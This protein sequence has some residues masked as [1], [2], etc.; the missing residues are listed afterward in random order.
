MKQRVF[1][2][3]DLQRMR[4]LLIEL[5]SAS[6]DFQVVGTACTEAEADQWLGA[7]G[8]AW[9]LAIIDMVLDE[10]S[11]SNVIRRAREQNYG[12]LIAVLSSCVT[13]NL[14]EHCYVLGA[15]KVFDEAQMTRFLLWLARVGADDA[16]HLQAA[17][18]E[19]TGVSVR[20]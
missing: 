8:E 17:A 20:A 11:G 5:F 15:D 13:D 19:A 14:R 1:I 4:E 16:P 2:A 3:E 7:N 9:D 18:A 12:G 10:G 6:G